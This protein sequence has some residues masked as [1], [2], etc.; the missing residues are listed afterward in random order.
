MSRISNIKTK[1]LEF[2]WFKKIDYKVNN[3][4]NAQKPLV[5]SLS[6]PCG[7]KKLLYARIVRQAHYERACL[8]VVLTKPGYLVLSL[9]NFWERIF[10]RYLVVEFTF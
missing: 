7:F 3:H 4:C 2:G 6:N 5:V 8:G 9:Y 1:Q 10:L